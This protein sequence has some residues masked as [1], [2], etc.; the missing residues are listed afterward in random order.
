MQS[1]DNSLRTSL[2]RRGIGP[3]PLPGARMVSRPGHGE[4][5]PRWIAAGHRAVRRMAER[6]QARTGV[7]ADPGGSVLDLLN[8]PMTAHFLG[9]CP[10]GAGP[11]SGVVDAYLRLYGHP[12]LHV[13]DGSAVPANLGVKPALTITALAERA[14][15]LWPNRGDP[16]P[17][18]APGQAYTR[19]EPAPP[20]RPAVP[21]GAP[22][23][24]RSTGRRSDATV[25]P[26]PGDS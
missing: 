6:L 18:P 5:N 12:G 9:G 10:I 17:R 22:G 11:D 13:V 15:A 4:P 25:S 19:L 23:A 1:R 2:R 26:D 14:F 16:D 20:R 8:V 24:L 3:V 21:A 7:P